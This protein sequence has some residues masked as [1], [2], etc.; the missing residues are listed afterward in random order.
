MSSVPFHE[1][2][3]KLSIMTRSWKTL[4]T[5]FAVTC[6][7]VA[8]SR[9]GAQSILINEI[10][11]KNSTGLV[12]AQGQYS[13]W[14]ELYNA[15]EEIVSLEGW[16]L[17]DNAG[18][19]MKWVFP[20]VELPPKS[21]LVVFCSGYD[22]RDPGGELHTNFQLDS[23]GEFLGLYRPGGTVEDQ[24]SPFLPKQFPD[25]SYGRRQS[26][27]ESV[28]V[29]LGD[30]M[31]YHVPGDDALGMSWAETDFDDASW[32]SGPGGIGF[33]R[34]FAPTFTELI[35]TDIGEIMQGVNASMVARLSF[36]AADVESIDTLSL[37][38]HYED[39]FVAFLNGARVASHNA[40]DNLL[41]NS[42]ATSSRTVASVLTG[43]R[44]LIED[45]RNRLRVGRNVLAI[46]GLNN[47]ISSTDFLLHPALNSVRLIEKDPR[48]LEFFEV[49]TPGLPNG[50]GSPAV[51]QLPVAD[52]ADGILTAPR[53]LTLTSPDG[54]EIHFT[55]GDDMSFEL[56]TAPIAIDSTTRIRA[57]A[58]VP[59]LISRPL[60]DFFF[61]ML[62]STLLDFSSD[63]PIFLI[64]TFG[65]E[66]PNEPKI[67]GFVHVVDV[68]PETGRSTLVSD[69]HY[70]GL[71]GI[72]GRGS[73]SAGR[74]K[75][76]YS[77]ELR[78]R[79]GDDFDFPLLGMPA[80]SD[81]VLYGPLNFDR[82]M[83]RN[84]FM[85]ELSNQVGLYGVRTQY[86][87]IFV[88]LDASAIDR[89]VDYYGVYAFMEKIKRGR[90]R[91]D[92]EEL[93][94][95]VRD[96]P[97]ISG[98]YMLKIDRAGPG[99]VGFTAGRQA[100]HHV[101]PREEDIPPHQKQW[102]ISHLNEFGNAL[103][104]AAY[105]DPVV[106]YEKYID[107]D[108]WIDFHILNEFA[109]NPDG[110]IFSTHFH[111]PRNGPIIM[112]PIWDF[113]RTMGNDDDARALNPVG[114]SDVRTHNWWG[115]LFT[116]PAFVKRYRHR[117]QELR[118]G[119]M[120][121]F[122]LF[123]IVDSMAAEIFE[124]QERNYQRWTGLVN[125]TPGWQ[126][127][128]RQLKDWIEKRANWMDTQLFSPPCVEPEGGLVELPIAI[129][130]TNSSFR[131]DLYYTLNGP[132]PR[133]LDLEPDPL[134]MIH[135]GQAIVISETTRVRARIR[136]KET[137]WSDLVEELYF[138][139]VPTLALSEIM[140]NPAGGSSFEFLEFY[141]YGDEPVRLHGASLTQGVL[142][143][144]A[145]GPEFLA[146]GAYTVVVSDLEDFMA[147]Y[148]TTGMSIS[149]EYSAILSDTGESVSLR[150][151]L[152]VEVFDF[153][154]SDAWYPETD[155]RGQSLVLVDLTT[156]PGQ[157]GEASSWRASLESGGSPGAEDPTEF[158]AGG[159]IP[160][161]SNQDGRLNISDALHL[162]GLVFEV[163]NGFPCEDGHALDTANL[164]V[165]DINGDSRIDGSDVVYA[166]LYL[167]VDGQ[168]PLQGVECIDARDCP[169][170]CGSEG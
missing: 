145:D 6:I 113:D 82:A 168:P 60:E 101:Y 97:E 164:L 128:I 63:I 83:I 111:K 162:V 150:G 122:N 8:T 79:N 155:G 43:D 165:F 57:R 158:S 107:V 11:T 163:P 56:Y 151:S 148:D 23:G 21:F 118:S 115:R 33:D 120:E 64:E 110:F 149:G 18:I 140:Y 88:N 28:L 20:A 37:H 31:R 112:G 14:V 160:G 156:P 125:G 59:G 139:E 86:V 138:S 126:N 70:S 170:V 65:G 136:L 142:L 130:L 131:G 141:N 134:A 89:Q 25:I 93:P 143:E 153:Q 144:I 30:N 114:W 90:D 69:P 99:D 42:R 4:K 94:L 123:A 68:D 24:I 116:D 26:V 13:D 78:D 66:I 34:K 51:A 84:P 132:D 53:M 72:E 129:Q 161:D 49:A 92:V 81:W 39:G 166:L 127:E 44:F 50:D 76:S 146:P 41:F 167:F 117:W 12:D 87:E 71:I 15:S 80:E 159:Q 9:A 46:Q 35:A 1:N 77:F 58:V 48:I 119:P 54:G 47:S 109:K 91:V 157:Y 27:E 152:G 32:D 2:A 169:N 17:T 137:V 108:N 7:V 104:G 45:H 135:E 5:W 73:S 67:P 40:P 62:D 105:R 74:V 36:D 52:T 147:R 75:K 3:Q 98:G 22:V 121:T 10:L 38:I 103:F 85:Y 124:A 133:Q 102:I 154:Y 55:R 16:A 96:E 100:M 29:A 106:G 19:P 95:T 61:P